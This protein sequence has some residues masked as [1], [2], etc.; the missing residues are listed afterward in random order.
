MIGDKIGCAL[1]DQGIEE[2]YVL[3]TVAR[4][5]ADGKISARDVAFLTEQGLSV[6]IVV[7]TMLITEK[8]NSPRVVWGAI[9]L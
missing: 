5:I 1:D 9:A 8:L 7:G 4:S 6:G 2:G 3:E